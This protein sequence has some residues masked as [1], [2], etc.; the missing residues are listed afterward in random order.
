MVKRT[1]TL[2]RGALPVVPRWG[3]SEEKKK[4]GDKQIYSLLAAARAR[5]LE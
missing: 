5:Q 4:N 2:K 1:K 3:P